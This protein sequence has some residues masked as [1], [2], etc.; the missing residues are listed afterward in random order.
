LRKDNLGHFL[1]HI[2]YGVLSTDLIET[3]FSVNMAILRA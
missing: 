2:S 1:V 3:L